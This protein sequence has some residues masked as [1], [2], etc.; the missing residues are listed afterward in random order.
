MIFFGLFYRAGSEVK[1]DITEKQVASI[2]RVVAQLEY[3]FI[4]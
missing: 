3:N 4:E 1:P 2:F